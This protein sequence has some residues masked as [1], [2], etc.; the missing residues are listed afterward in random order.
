MKTEAIVV[1]ED[2]VARLEPVELPELT[3]TRVRIATTLS[4]VSCGT[5]ADSTSGRGTYITR[6][7][8]AGY[9]AV[10]R[11]AEVGSKVSNLRVGDMVFTT[12]GGLWNRPHLFGGSHA[13]KLV[14]EAAD[15]VA[16]SPGNPSLPS[17]AYAALA[18]VGLEGLLRIPLEP[19]RVLLVLGLGM[20]GHMAGR[21]AQLRGLRV[22]GA[23]R[24][25]WKRDTAQAFGFDAVCPPEAEAIQA[26]VKSLGFGAVRYVV[27]TTGHPTMFEL[28][29]TQLEPCG[30]LSLLG[31]Y[32]DPYPVNFDACHAKRLTIHNPVGW[33]IHLPEV[34]Q[35]IEEGRLNVESLIRRCLTPSQITAFYADLVQN[36]SQYLGA[37]IDWCATD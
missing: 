31:Y 21:L 29:L 7:F 28:A 23:N 36:H 17:S 20:L 33:G 14:V 6:P 3:P 25:L 4:G 32:P 2:H 34:I 10:G 12:G 13:R 22:V 8:I 35:R 15:V 26:Q 27:D 37:I 1:G 30:E 19:G 18:A 24:S 11:V 16:L 5:E 9:Q